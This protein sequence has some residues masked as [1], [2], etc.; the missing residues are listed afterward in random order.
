M[1]GS[2]PTAVEQS[3]YLNMG[4][5]DWHHL[6]IDQPAR[7]EARSKLAKALRWLADKLEPRI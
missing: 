5:Y 6:V 3:L 2:T 4:E 7:P 1:P